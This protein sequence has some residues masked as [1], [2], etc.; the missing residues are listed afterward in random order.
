MYD[1]RYKILRA[2]ASSKS[3]ITVFDVCRFW[4]IYSEEEALKFSPEIEKLV[5]EEVVENDKGNLTLV[6]PLIPSNYPY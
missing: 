3:P 1:Y 4:G 2:L 5:R 6:R